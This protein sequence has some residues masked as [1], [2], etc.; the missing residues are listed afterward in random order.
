MKRVF[1]LCLCAV[2]F[3]FGCGKNS[4]EDEGTINSET[5]ENNAV[6]ISESID[7]TST[8]DITEEINETVSHETVFLEHYIRTI[9]KCSISEEY[10]YACLIST[11]YELQNYLSDNNDKF[12]FSGLY[13]FAEQRGSDWY[14]E[15]HKLLFIVVEEPAYDYWHEVKSLTESEVV[16]N[17]HCPVSGAAFSEWHIAVEVPRDFNI[18]ADFMITICEADNKSKEESFTYKDLYNKKIDKYIIEKSFYG[19]NAANLDYDLIYFDGDDTP[20]LVIGLEGYF[21]SLYTCKNGEIVPIY[22]EQAYGAGGNDGIYY[23]PYEGVVT[24]EGNWNHAGA[25]T[26]EIYLKWDGYELKDIN[27]ET[28]LRRY[29]YDINEDGKY[30]HADI[31]AGAYSETPLYFVGDKPVSEKEFREHCI[32]GDYELLHGRLSL[33]EIRKA[34]TE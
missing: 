21:V 5:V 8:E 26:Y 23:L 1:I 30:D 20:E 3:L 19:D 33:E 14:W 27:T 31:A 18:Q 24:A 11:N 6:S 34:L 29:Y 7:N 28:L 16:I 9:D 25:D 17:K 13:A 22:E 32:E 2:L 15:H 12:D 10:P 4:A